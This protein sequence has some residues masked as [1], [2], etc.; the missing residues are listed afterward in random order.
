MTVDWY[1]DGDIV[2]RPHVPKR[3]FPATD[4][5]NRE[6]ISAE[7]LAIERETVAVAVGAQGVEVLAPAGRM[8]VIS[9]HSLEDRQ[10][11]YYFRQEAQKAPPSVRLLTRRPVRP[12]RAEQERNP[13]SRSAKL[14]AVEK[15]AVI[16][17]VVTP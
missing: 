5:E 13:R 7:S 15:L 4:D 3:P 9:F 6:A 14:R 16:P 11:K 17:F 8:V 12:D 1:G 10:A 2:H